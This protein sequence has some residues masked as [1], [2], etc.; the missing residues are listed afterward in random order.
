MFLISFF[1]SYVMEGSSSCGRPESERVDQT[2]APDQNCLEPWMRRPYHD[3][4]GLIT[5]TTTTPRYLGN[6]KHHVWPPV[7]LCTAKQRNCGKAEDVHG[8]STL[9]QAPSA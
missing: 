1:M 2:Q 6:K 9:R 3:Q 5:V 8:H 4:P 7:V